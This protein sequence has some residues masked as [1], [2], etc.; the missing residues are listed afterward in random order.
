MKGKDMRSVAEKRRD[1]A[2]VAD[3]FAA[4]R[5]HMRGPAEDAEVNVR[6]R[7]LDRIVA[8]L[9]DLGISGAHL[10]QRVQNAEADAVASSRTDSLQEDR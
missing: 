2:V 3:E 10:R 1:P 8:R 5:A 6:L 7:D 4:R 9:L